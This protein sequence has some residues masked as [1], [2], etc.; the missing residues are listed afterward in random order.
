MLIK[1]HRSQQNI[2]QDTFDMLLRTIHAIAIG[3][4]APV[5]HFH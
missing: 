5:D 3:I 4:E 1:K 2:D